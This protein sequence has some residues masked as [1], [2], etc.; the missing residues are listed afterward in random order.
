MK[1]FLDGHPLHK[2]YGGE[3]AFSEKEYVDAMKSAGFKIQK[4]WRYYDSV[5]NFYP[6]K[7]WRIN[8]AK[9]KNAL[10]FFRPT[11]LNEA[12]I[13]GRMYSFLAIK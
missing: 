1:Q 5:L 4:V 6:I 10:L 8:A 11:N 13:P 9:A 3:N 7:R 2:F 12:A